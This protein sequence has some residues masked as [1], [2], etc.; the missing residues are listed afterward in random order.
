M[1]E[2]FSRSFTNVQV[3]VSPAPKPMDCGSEPS[4]QVS[5]TRFQPVG[6]V[7]DTSYV[8]ARRSEKVSESLPAAPAAVVVSVNEEGDSEFDVKSNAPDPSRRLAPRS[9]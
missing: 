1:I 9:M 7:S 8:P 3:T 4:L 2:P 5:L 6:T